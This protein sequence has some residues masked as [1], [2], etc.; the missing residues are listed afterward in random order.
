MSAIADQFLESLRGWL[1]EQVPSGWE[2]FQVQ[3][4]VADA[5]RV[6]PGVLLVYERSERQPVG[7]ETTEK[8][9]A[10]VV[11]RMQFDDTEADAFRAHALEVEGWLRTLYLE[12]KPGP[13]EGLKL[14]FFRIDDHARGTPEGDRVAVWKVS[15]MVTLTSD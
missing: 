2:G 6:C 11:L 13:L 5:E 7:M 14:H 15:A 1:A 10:M 12:A 8:V 4:Q 3:Q 9:H